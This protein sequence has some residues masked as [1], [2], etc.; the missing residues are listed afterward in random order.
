MISDKI[1]LRCFVRRE[2]HLCG[3]SLLIQQWLMINIFTSSPL[4]HFYMSLSGLKPKTDDE[5]SSTIAD[6]NVLLVELET[7]IRETMLAP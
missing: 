7:S 3:S 1:A 2:A 6:G 4:L 5:K